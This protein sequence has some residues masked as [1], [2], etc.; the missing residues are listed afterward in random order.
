MDWFRNLSPRGKRVAII[1]GGAGLAL[2]LI[3][4]SR[5]GQAA[6]PAAP[7]DT[8]GEG[9]LAGGP[10]GV[11]PGTS[12]VLPNAD[13]DSSTSQGLADL[14][15]EVN[16]IRGDI[17]AIP[18]LIPVPSGASEVAQAVGDVLRPIF[19]GALAAP[20]TTAPPITASPAPAARPQPA[21]KPPVTGP[22]GGRR[23]GPWDTAAKR[24]KAVAGIPAGKVRKYSQGGKF[25]AEIFD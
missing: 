23:V 15:D 18:G 12:G 4:V 17:A 20:V 6:A 19:D 5:R 13:Y 25:Y 22:V 8:S 21:A 16:A 24:D 7:V 11:I 9:S 1:A 14:R 2:I 10:G 3:M